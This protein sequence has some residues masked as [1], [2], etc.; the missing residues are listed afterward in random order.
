MWWVIAVAVVCLVFVMVW[1]AP[2]I[3]QAT[4]TRVAGDDDGEIFVRYLYGLVQIRRS[5]S[6]LNTSMTEKG[7]KLHVHHEG[8]RNPNQKQEK[9]I[10]VSDVWNVL[11][12]L[13]KWMEL[14]HKMMPVVRKLWRNARA[15]FF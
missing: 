2:I 8:A 7:P 5:L 11:G 15:L 9:I 4:F 1:T 6:M 3:I 12:K 14:F 13:P 10:S